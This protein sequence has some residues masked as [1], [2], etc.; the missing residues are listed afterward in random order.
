MKQVEQYNGNYK[1]FLHDLDK[2]TQEHLPFKVFGPKNKSGVFHSFSCLGQIYKQTEDPD[3]SQNRIYKA[4]YGEIYKYGC[5]LAPVVFSAIQASPKGLNQFQGD[6]FEL[7]DPLDFMVQTRLVLLLSHSCEVD[8]ESIVSV[9]PVYKESDLEADPRKV[10]VLRG[11]A[12]KDHKAAIK[13]WLSNESKLIVG[14][15]PLDIDGN[16]ERL[17]IYLRDVKTIKKNL[18]PA[19]PIIRLSYRGLSY[20]QIRVAHFFFR[21]VQDSDESRNL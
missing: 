12:P 9:I 18:L 3:K 1:T 2:A 11:S 17:A 6:L 13:N 14:L 8:R 15:P 5:R 19:A 10:E 16:S 7:D 21:D 4:P 20:L